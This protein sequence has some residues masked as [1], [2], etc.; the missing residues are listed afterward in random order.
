MLLKMTLI[1]RELEYKKKLSLSQTKLFLFVNVNYQIFSYFYD[2]IIQIF[3]NKY[4]NMFDP[5]KF[6]LDLDKSK[7]ET[8][9]DKAE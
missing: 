2:K 7:N 6:E 4:K 9:N 8:N 3:N 1:K 5:S